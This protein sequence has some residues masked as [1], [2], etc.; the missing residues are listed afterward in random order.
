MPVYSFVAYSH[1]PKTGQ[2]YPK[3][4]PNATRKLDVYFPGALQQCVNYVKQ[5][6]LLPPQVHYAVYTWDREIPQ[7]VVLAVEP[8]Y[9]Q[10]F[11]GPQQPKLSKQHVHGGQ[12]VGAPTRQNQGRLDDRPDPKSGFQRLGDA[13][14]S[15]GVDVMFGAPD[16]GTV[17]DLVHG[18]DGLTE[19]ERPK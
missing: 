12:P 8:A 7:P 19:M 5:Q 4:P 3:L 15:S 2:A 11:S 14:L 10:Q 13:A 17:T 16:D 6:Q 1:D 18:P 9:V